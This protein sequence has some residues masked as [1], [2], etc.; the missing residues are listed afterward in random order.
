MHRPR[1]H[2]GYLVNVKNA[3]GSGDEDKG[4]EV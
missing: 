2:N 1:I 3:R 4:Y